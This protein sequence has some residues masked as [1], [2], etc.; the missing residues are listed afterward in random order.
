MNDNQTIPALPAHRIDYWDNL[1]GLLIILVVIG[2]FL[3][4]CSGKAG[5]LVAWI[6]TFHMPA[7]IFVAGYLTSKKSCGTESLVKILLLYLMLQG[8]M[9]PFGNSFQQCTY[10]ITQSYFSAWFMLALLLYRLTA[11][12]IRKIGFVLF[13]FSLLLSLLIGFTGNSLEALCLQKIIALWPFFVTGVLMQKIIPRDGVRKNIK[14]QIAFVIVAVVTTC[15]VIFLLKKGI[16]DFSDWMWGTYMGLKGCSMRVMMFVIAGSYIASLLFLCPSKKIPMITQWGKSSLSIYVLHRPISLLTPMVVANLSHVSLL[17]AAIFCLFLVGNTFVSRNFARL[18]TFLSRGLLTR[19]LCR[20]S[21]AGWT[22][23]AATAVPF[24]LEPAMRIYNFIIPSECKHID[25]LEMLSDEQKSELSQAVKISYVGDLILLRPMIQKAFDPIS[26]DYDFSDMFEWTKDY[27]HSDDLTIGVFEGPCAGAEDGYSSGDCRQKDS[28]PWKWFFLNYPD[29]FA[30]AVKEAGV[31]LVT[32]SNNHLLD[33]GVAGA[34]RTLS[35]LENN[36]LEVT[37]G[38]RN[39]E[40]RNNPVRLIEVK[41]LRIAVLAYSY[42]QNCVEG[43]EKRLTSPIWDLTGHLV[44]PDSPH[45]KKIEQ[46]IAEDFSK[47]KAL[48][49]DCIIVMPHWGTEFCHTAD[50]YQ[51][52]WCRFFCEQGA[53]LILGCHPHCTQPI[54]WV[55]GRNGETSL[56]VYCPGNY[57]NSYYL[58]DG[59]ATIIA[60]IYLS[61]KNGK[62][63]A[64]GIKPTWGTAMNGGNWQ[65]MPITKLLERSEELPLTFHDW[66]R[67]EKVHEIITESVLGHKIPLAACPECY[68]VLRDHPN[69]IYRGPVKAAKLSEDDKREPMYQLLLN[70]KSI[71]FVGDSVTEGTKNFG[72]GWYEPIAE[73]LPKHIAINRFAKGGATSQFFLENIEKYAQNKAGT[74]VIAFGTNDVRYRMPEVCAMDTAAYIDRVQ[75]IVKRL[76]KDNPGVNIVFIAPWTTDEYDDVSVL[77]K[78]DRYK[79]LAEYAEAL[80][81]YALDHECYYVDPTQAIQK[82]M[83]RQEQY[84]DRVMVDHVHPNASKGIYMYSRAVLRSPLER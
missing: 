9:C 14:K 17:I 35:V 33:R 2:H 39:A 61:P 28:L 7:F 23:V 51:Q 24:C 56:V 27:F 71:C 54:E 62:P 77:E 26:G 78:E 68:Y 55:K 21:I 50:K 44:S 43:D 10:N 16:I 37:G 20:G 41:G 66:E 1:K 64:Y 15:V 58:G 25:A 83:M 80:R 63:I 29:S 74:Y 57:V 69:K 5:M 75:A 52:K 31:D 3:L 22:V 73:A 13:F 79:M 38:Y 46:Q 32:V 34:L 84:P 45:I 8:F 19:T 30:K 65:A 42:G 81:K 59:D 60:D 18:L 4:P 67:I 40:E 6:Y 72:Y 76:K 49:P 48:N 82:E 70:S 11:P 47:A 36:Q 53:D 12:L